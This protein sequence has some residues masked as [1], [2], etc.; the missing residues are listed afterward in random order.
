MT[1]TSVAVKSGDLILVDSYLP[2]RSEGQR[3]FFFPVFFVFLWHNCP[4][5]RLLFLMLRLLFLFSLLKYSAQYLNI[6]AAP[7]SPQ[8]TLQRGGPTEGPICHFIPKKTIAPTWRTCSWLSMVSHW[9]IYLLMLI[10]IYIY[11][12]MY[13]YNMCV[14]VYICIYIAWA[15]FRMP[16]STGAK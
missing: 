15:L 16:L 12:C 2:Q 9:S 11:I 13:I 5:S 7:P 14:C 4:F 8:E 6:T 3:P 1:F 10:Y